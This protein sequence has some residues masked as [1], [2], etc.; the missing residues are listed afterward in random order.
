[1]TRKERDRKIRK[2]DILRTAE[3]LFATKGFH[4]T[5]MADIAREAEYAVGTIYLYFKDKE[6][7]Y[8][9]L[10]EEKT[11]RTFQL[12]K[13]KVDQVQGA[14]NKIRTLI[15]EHLNNFQENEDFFRIYF[16]DRGECRWTIKD[17]ISRT[18]VEGF[19]KYIGYISQLVQL[20]QVER[21]IRKELDPK[22]CAHILAGMLNGTVVPWLVEG[23]SP[24]QGSLKGMSGAI[25][26][27][28]L[29]GAG[30]HK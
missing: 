5:T 12:V 22:K 8:L 29:N 20:A 7:I 14:E 16:S 2:D 10:I 25:L 6:Q 24:K 18:A 26:D 28:F 17:K 11:G 27:F 23:G 15:E 9:T 19:I 30:L 1:M 13:E 21:V 3:R 4:L